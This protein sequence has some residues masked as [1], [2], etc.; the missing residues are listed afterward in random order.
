M[1]T[2]VY[3]SSALK[4]ERSKGEYVVQALYH[5]Y[6]EHLDLLPNDYLAW[7]EGERSRAVVDYISGLTDNY[8]IDQ[9]QNYFVPRH[10]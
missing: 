4:E 10:G 2:Q 7:D 3:N 9:F 6:L 8:A 1:F 5:Y